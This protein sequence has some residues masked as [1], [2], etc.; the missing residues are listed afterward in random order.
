[1]KQTRYQDNNY[2]YIFERIFNLFK[3]YLQIGKD[4]W[5]ND[6]DGNKSITKMRLL[7]ILQGIFSGFAIIG[8]YIFL[9]YMPLGVALAIIYAC[10]IIGIVLP[11]IFP[12]KK[13][14]KYLSLILS[15]ILLILCFLFLPLVLFYLNSSQY[16]GSQTN[17]TIFAV[18]NTTHQK[19]AFDNVTGNNY[20]DSGELKGFV[21]IEMY[22]LG[23]GMALLISISDAAHKIIVG[24]LYGNKSTESTLLTTYYAGYGGIFV[25]LIASIFDGNQKI[26][27]LNVINVPSLYWGILFGLA[28]L[29]LITFIMINAAVKLIRPLILALVKYRR[30]KTWKQWK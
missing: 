11:R 21:G 2:G 15:A 8:G 16:T 18:K 23:V 13:F 24:Y 7:S 17:P 28:F 22:Y 1:M 26:L 14:G 27:S 6:V 5:I 30:T 12:R 25:G 29:K 3:W 19:S 9:F 20:L 4:L 10:P